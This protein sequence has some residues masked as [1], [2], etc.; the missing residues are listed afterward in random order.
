MKSHESDGRKERIITL[1]LS[2]EDA[3]RLYIKSGEAGISMT[4]LIENFI[5]DLT[6]S[7]RSNG[8]D[9]EDLANQWFERCMFGM[10]SNRNFLKFIIERGEYEW[11]AKTWTDLQEA[12]KRLAIGISDFCDQEEMD[13]IRENADYWKEILED[14]YQQF[15][16]YGDGGG[17]GMEEDFKELVQWKQEFDVFMRGGSS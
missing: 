6:F 7:R 1:R 5:Q 10:L 9:E 14:F 12:K 17:K 16:E 11:A 13:A 3:E 4:E 15:E 8:S 2:D